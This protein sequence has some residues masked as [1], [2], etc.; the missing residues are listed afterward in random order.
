V[1]VAALIGVHQIFVGKGR[2]GILVQK[3]LIGVRGG[4]VYVEVVLLDVLAMVALAVGEPKEPLLEYGVP[5]V[6]NREGQAEQLLIVAQAGDPV[7]A[8]AVGA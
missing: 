7:L 1:T 2:L 6:P 3:A 5:A 8:P 4:G